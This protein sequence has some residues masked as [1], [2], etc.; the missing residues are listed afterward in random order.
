MMFTGETALF[1]NVI[2]IGVLS[3]ALTSV[4]LC[5]A[6]SIASPH[7]SRISSS[8]REKLLWGIA[9]TPWLSVFAAVSLLIL[10][11]FLIS[12]N[13][14][15]TER[16]HWHHS[17]VFDVNSWHGVVS[18]LALLF[19][20]TAIGRTSRKAL[21]YSRHVSQL[22]F[23]SETDSNQTV[24]IDTE[25]LHAFTA[26]WINPQVF[27]SKG[28]TK[29]L[30]SQDYDVVLKHE[31]A[32]ARRLDPLR[33][34]LFSYLTMFFPAF[35]SRRLNQWMLVSIEQR[36]DESAMEPSSCRISMAQ[37]LV[38]VTRLFEQEK[39]N[40]LQST[41]DLCAYTGSSLE[42]R[43]RSILKHD[44]TSTF[45]ALPALAISFL[46]LLLSVFLVDWFHHSIELFLFH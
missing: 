20:L 27:L 35:M 29:Q 19:V 25:E 3:F 42:I 10:P 7:L 43:I 24:T 4:M 39:Y 16:F 11:E 22:Q 13:H 38:K 23:F 32:H 41:N 31:L 45:V 30:S 12:S 14:W 33:I 18:I 40:K 37:T 17:L 26:G 8:V 6:F 15:F 9:L 1:F 28:L 21:R 34:L 36:A 5:L 2:T 46:L 44:E